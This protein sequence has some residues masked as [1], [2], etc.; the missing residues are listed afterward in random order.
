MKNFLIGAL[1]MYA[2]LLT[3]FE[4]G[5]YNG[6]VWASKEEIQTV[7]LKERPQP[8]PKPETPPAQKQAAKVMP[9][10]LPNPYLAGR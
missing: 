6:N 9:A 7:S 1:F 10:D 5:R 4:L 2:A 8:A 3:C